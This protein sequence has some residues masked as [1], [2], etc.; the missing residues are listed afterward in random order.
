MDDFDFSGIILTCFVIIVAGALFF[1]FI[2]AVKKSLNKSDE[3]P[4]V[5]SS[6]M[7]REQDERTQ[8][9][10]YDHDKMM[11][12]QEQK[13]KDGEKLMETRS[14]S[15]QEIQRRQ[16]ELMRDMEQRIKDMQR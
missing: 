10:Q 2:G 16:D 13:I 8:Q 4:I 11:D 12:G 6:Q 9:I 14:A 15:P 7:L 5:D 3:T 1:G